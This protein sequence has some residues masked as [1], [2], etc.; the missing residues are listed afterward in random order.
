MREIEPK[1]NAASEDAEA[2]TSA[3]LSRA[4]A[5]GTAKPF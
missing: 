4:I 1:H 2:G 5:N 3:L